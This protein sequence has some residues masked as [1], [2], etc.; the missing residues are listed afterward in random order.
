MRDTWR[1]IYLKLAKFYQEGPHE[2]KV[3]LWAVAISAAIDLAA[4][5]VAGRP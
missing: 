5:F 3:F 2:R 1:L 4:V